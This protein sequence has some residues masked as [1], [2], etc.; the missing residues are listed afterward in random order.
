MIRKKLSATAAI[1]FI[2]LT[3]NAQQTVGLFSNTPESFDGYTLFAPMQNTTTYLINNCGEM[4]HSWPATNRPAL[5]VYLLESGNL[6]RTKNMA[7]ANFSAGGS[8]GGVEM[9]DWDGNVIWSYTI[10]GATEC[11]HHDVEYLPNGNILFVAWEKR[12]DQE[13]IQ[14]GRTSVGSSLWPEKIVEVQPDLQNGGGTVVWEWKVWDHLVQDQDN[15]K[16]NF[17][18]VA[19]SPELIDINYYIGNATKADWLHINSVSYNAALDQIV[20]S[21]HNFSEFWIIDHST[22]TTEAASHTGGTQNKG[23]DILYRWGNPITYDQG[24]AGNQKLVLQHDAN[25]IPEGYPDAGKIMIFNNQA[26]T[27]YSEVNIIDTPVDGSG[28]YSYSGGA[29]EPLDYSWTYQAPTPTDF[30]SS[31]ISGANR[32]ANG[33]TLICEGTKGHF[34]EVDYSG[35]IVWEYVNPVGV[36]ILNQ[37]ENVVQNP[38]FRCT[39]YAQDYPGLIGKTLMPQGYIEN[40]SSF[41]CDLFAAI[42]EASLSSIDIF[43]NPT[44]DRLSIKSEMIVQQVILFDALGN[45]VHT[46]KWSK[47]EGS[48]DVNSLPKGLYFLELVTKTGKIELRK[49][50]IE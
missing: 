35:N 3:L 18:S 31:I 48:I 45:E 24:T 47:Y 27:L 28:N 38:A 2:S 13:A 44:S 49:V 23:G 43:P 50:M 19:D 16:D 12:T 46:E 37:G 36:S 10:S 11:Q 29:Y 40:G 15:S 41:S 25:W 5:S 20:M 14:A 4:V 9:I 22:T 42:E 21:V 1:L 33:N 39:R 17:G 32:L 6:L 34:F 8:G 26:G 7:N 30:Y